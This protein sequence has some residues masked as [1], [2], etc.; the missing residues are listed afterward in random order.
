MTQVYIYGGCN[1]VK[2]VGSNSFLVLDDNKILYL[3]TMT[4]SNTTSQ[5][6]SLMALIRA[7]DYI[8]DHVTEFANTRVTVLSN[9]SYVI[10]PFAKRWIHTWSSNGWFS[11]S[12]TLIKNQ[13]LFDRAYKKYSYLHNNHCFLDFKKADKD[14]PYIKRLRRETSYARKL[15]TY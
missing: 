5:K 12:D 11:S 3:D 9:N 7:L 4:N 10:D 2:G 1:N 14:D 13:E 6:E 8:E 15:N